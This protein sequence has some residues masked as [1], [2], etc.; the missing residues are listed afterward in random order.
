[1]GEQDEYDDEDG[2]RGNGKMLFYIM[3]VFFYVY[4]SIVYDIGGGDIDP[5]DDCDDV[6]SNTTKKSS[7]WWS[8]LIPFHYFA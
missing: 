3:K 7:S 2:G 5:I 4:L 8:Y 1:M 6:D